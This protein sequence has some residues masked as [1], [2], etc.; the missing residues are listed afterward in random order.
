MSVTSH[1]PYFR[2][3]QRVHPGSSETLYVYRHRII[4][5]QGW[6]LFKVYLQLLFFLA[7]TLECGVNI[8]VCLQQLKIHKTDKINN[9]KA[10]FVLNWRVMAGIY[11]LIRLHSLYSSHTHPLFYYLSF[12][13]ARTLIDVIPVKWS[14]TL[15]MRLAFL[16]H[17]ICFLCYFPFFVCVMLNIETFPFS[18]IQTATCST[19]DDA[20]LCL[21]SSNRPD[22]SRWWRLTFWNAATDLWISRNNERRYMNGR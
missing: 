10:T 6:F 7:R 20:L 14:L 17:W 18:E 22:I 8:E 11:V 15:F 12:I 13:L 9:Y 16:H 5:F 1:P 3:P 19:A 4:L 2:W 21:S